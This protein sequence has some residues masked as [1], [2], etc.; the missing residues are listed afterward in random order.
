MKNGWVFGGPCLRGGL[1]AGGGRFALL[2][3][4]G[5][6]VTIGFTAND[7]P[8][9]V[10]FVVGDATGDGDIT[11]LLDGRLAFPRYGTTPCLSAPGRTA[12]CEGEAVVYLLII[13]EG[14]VAVQTYGAPEIDVRSLGRFHPGGSCSVD[15]MV[16]TDRA[17]FT[18]AWIAHR[19][20]TIV[21]AN[22]VHFDPEPV[23]QD[24]PVAGAF[25]VFA[26]VCKN[27]AA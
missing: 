1:T 27:K 9:A 13:N 16:L 8:E 3:Y 21:S 25:S 11:G 19:A 6:S 2:E 18:V 14:T 20:T 15:S 24:Y 26:I 5:V 10:P 7:A 4:R 22:M 12:R 23:R 17:R